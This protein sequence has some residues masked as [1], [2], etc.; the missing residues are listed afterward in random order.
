MILSHQSTDDRGL[1]G[2][3]LPQPKTTHRAQV[4]N[5]MFRLA[6]V[7]ETCSATLLDAVSANDHSFAWYGIGRVCVFAC[8]ASVCGNRPNIIRAQVLAARVKRKI[9]HGIGKV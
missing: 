4:R 1:I 7:E 9:N 8:V 3:F 5:G 2:P 6:T